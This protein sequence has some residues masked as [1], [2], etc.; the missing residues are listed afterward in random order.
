MTASIVLTGLAADDPI[1]NVYVELNFAQGEATGSGVGQT[2]LC[3]ANKIA[4]GEGIV[5]SRIYGPDTD[6]PLQ[7]EADMIRLAGAGSEA[8]RMFRRIANV[9]RDTRVYWVFVTESAGAKATG[10]MVLSGGVPAVGGNMRVHVGDEFVDTPLFAGT[11]I[12]TIGAEVAANINKKAHWPVTAAYNSSTDTI[13]LTAKQNGLRGNLIRFMASITSTGGAIGTAT[14]STTDGFLSGGTTADS[15]AAA[16]VTVAARR[17]DYI[18]SA[19]EDATQLGALNAQVGTQALPTTNIRQRWVAGSVDTLGAITTIATGLNATL[20]E[21][22]WSEKSPWTPAELAAN[23]AAVITLREA[24]VNFLTNFANYGNDAI[25]QLTW[26]V[27]KSRVDSAAPSRT[28]IKSALNNG[29][30]PIA[31]NPSGSTYLVDRITTRSLSGA[32][33]DYRIRDASKVSI[34]YR[35]ADDVQTKIALQSAGKRIANDPAEGA[36]PPGGNVMTPRIVRGMIVGEIDR[37]AEND[38]LQDVDK[39]KNGLVVQRE[40]VPSTRMTARIPLRP[41]DGFK[42]M[43]L[44]IDQVA[45][46]LGPAIGFAAAAAA[47]LGS[48]LA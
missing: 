38:L 39:I 34:C 48:F 29:I 22:V 47:L 18:V 42:Q 24:G 15:N 41:I 14:T 21:I 35:F 2:I 10:T 27:P 16:L 7:T 9:N 17:F 26:L 3:L 4:A 13:T 23:H 45:G 37:Y 28:S 25:S 36:R 1:P 8:H 31:V 12:D 33:A 19:A 44:A 40:T 11:A 6:P 30:S 20:G 46:F 5:D 32:I 43:G